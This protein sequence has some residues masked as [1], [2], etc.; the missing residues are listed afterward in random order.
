MEQLTIYAED[1]ATKEGVE[2]FLENYKDQV[3]QFLLNVLRN[4]TGE[5]D[6]TILKDKEGVFT[7]Y[8]TAPD[9]GWVLTD[10]G[11]PEDTPLVSKQYNTVPTGERYVIFDGDKLALFVKQPE[12]KPDLKIGKFVD[13]NMAFAAINSED[14]LKAIEIA[15]DRLETNSKEESKL[16][17]KEK[18]KALASPATVNNNNESND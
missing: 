18:L 16:A 15:L 4:E 5:A 17:R 14:V 8:R 2:L 7:V 1:K 12:G 9:K 11:A 3:S 6:P 13:L 10:F